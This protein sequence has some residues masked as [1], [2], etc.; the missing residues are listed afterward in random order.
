MTAH[1]A[2]TLA[3]YQANAETYVQAR[4]AALAPELHDFLAR[5]APGS[6]IL[7]LGCGSGIDAQALQERG[8]D[9]VASD[10]TPAMAALASARLGRPVRV[11]RFDELT[12]VAAYDAVIA[13]AALLHVPREGLPGVLARIHSALKPGG[14]HFATYKTGA[15][16]GVD[17]YGR[18][19]N[20]L[21]Q[22]DAEALYRAAAP[23]ASLGCQQWDGVGYFSA[24]TRWLAMTAQRATAGP[25]STRSAPRRRR[26]A[27]PAVR[28]ATVAAP[29]SAQTG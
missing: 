11:M 17:E 1:D 18:F 2:A 7:E 13:S 24:P 23:W 12:D 20:Q 27:P 16:A 15:A 28:S 19:Y 3:F 25:G 14:W 29:L 8:Y 10:A 26:P 5:L 21:A 22:S 6:R 4:P 9:V